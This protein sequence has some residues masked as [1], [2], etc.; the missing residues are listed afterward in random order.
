MKI[1]K[2]LLKYF[3]KQHGITEEVAAETLF[4]PSEDGKDKLSK[5]KDSLLK[6]LLDKDGE[7]IEA[8]K[9]SVDTSK[10]ITEGYNKAMGEVL[11]NKEKA[12]AKKYGIE[13]DEKIGFDGLM[14][15]IIT[16]QIKA[17]TKEGDVLT[18]EAIKKTPTFLSLEKSKADLEAELKAKHKKEVDDLK[19]TYKREK[20]F[21][22]STILSNLDKLNPVLPKSST[23]AS[24]Q[25]K[26]F[27]NEIKEK[28][29]FEGDLIVDK[30]TNKRVED[31]HG[32]PVKIETITEEIAASHFDFAKQSKKAAPDS[33]NKNSKTTTATTEVPDSEEAYTK[34]IMAAKTPEERQQIKA[35]YEESEGSDD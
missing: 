7:R 15:S 1:E 25:R 6:T 10:F 32:N 31:K 2:I 12:L 23:A 29:V 9:K 11:S 35:A 5:P 8:T 18:P 19:L 27:L 24:T 14:D 30:A 26:N 33:K 22:E 28:Y 13:Y 16:K 21:P 4:D 3:A 17:S 20:N 34:Q